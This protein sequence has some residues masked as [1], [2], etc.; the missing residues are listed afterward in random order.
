MNT[1]MGF[2]RMPRVIPSGARNLHLLVLA[3]IG[4]A[5]WMPAAAA[6]EAYKVPGAK[7]GFVTTPDGVKIHYL[8]VGKPTTKGSVALR[9]NPPKLVLA[10]EAESPAILFVPGWTMP[11]WI[12]EKQ[13][14]HF[15]K[16][17]RVVAMDPRSQGESQQTTEGHYPAARARDIKA[18]VD[19]LKLAPVVLV[20]WSMGVTEIAAYVDQFGTAD[21]AGLVLVDGIAGSDYD[22]EHTPGFLQWAAS[23]QRDRQKATDA[24][25]RFMYMNPAVKAD[26][27]YL[28]RVIQ[29][30]L[31]TPTNTAAALLL[32]MVTTD[33]RP[34]LAKIDKPT[35]IVVARSPWLPFYEDLHKR[36]AGSEFALMDNVGH[37]LFVDDPERFNLLLEK[38]LEPL[39][40][41]LPEPKVYQQR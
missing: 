2:S 19:Q 7:D 4:A 29:A 24:F 40:V 32:G 16:T 28:Q 18:V 6:A 15:S 36:V 33:N 37:A 10:I 41:K 5:L 21:L 20:G 31:G 14:A 12:W 27:A 34:A 1:D 17:H 9:G 39:W 25:F 13:I 8:E 35:L 22:P 38:F 30:S 23:F 11:A 26:E 3:L